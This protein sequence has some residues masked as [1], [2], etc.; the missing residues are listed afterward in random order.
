MLPL[1]H[2]NCQYVIAF[3]SKACMAPTVESER[4]SEGDLDLLPIYRQLA[5]TDRI[6]ADALQQVEQFACLNRGRVAHRAGP[7]AIG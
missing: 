3:Y 7:I 6:E 1:V 5:K 4:T 2:S